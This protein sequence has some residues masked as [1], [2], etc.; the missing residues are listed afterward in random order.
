[1][2]SLIFPGYAPNGGGEV[3]SAKSACRYLIY[4]SENT[5]PEQSIAGFHI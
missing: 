1:M 4:H 5:S 2:F 3:L